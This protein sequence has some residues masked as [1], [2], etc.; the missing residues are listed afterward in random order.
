MR[1]PGGAAEE[2][3]LSPRGSPW[4]KLRRV[5]PRAPPGAGRASEQHGACSHLAVIAEDAGEP[6]MR[7]THALA[8]GSVGGAQGGAALSPP[9]RQPTSATRGLAPSWRPERSSQRATGYAI[10]ALAWVCEACATNRATSARHEQSAGSPDIS[11]GGHRARPA[12]ESARISPGRLMLKRGLSC[13]QCTSTLPAEACPQRVWLCLPRLWSRR[14]SPCEQ[15]GRGK[16]EAHL[17][18]EPAQGE[19]ARA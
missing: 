11:G 6:G 10:C 1:T 4:P 5:R 15:V 13:H 14:D 7:R 3:E 12:G 9:L 17:P 19:S 2:V 8:Q 18:Q 16:G